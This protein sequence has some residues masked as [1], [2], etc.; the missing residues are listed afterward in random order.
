VRPRTSEC[1]EEVYLEIVE[2]NIAA[3]ESAT[4]E[5]LSLRLQ[6]LKAEAANSL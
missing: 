1:T 6:Q 3:A 5:Q 4:P 2:N